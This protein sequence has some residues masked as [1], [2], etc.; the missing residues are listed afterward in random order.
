[1]R[2]WILPLLIGLLAT[3]A[4]AQADDPATTDEELMFLDGAPEA[5]PHTV[6]VHVEMLN[7][8]LLRSDSD[9]D[10]SEPIY[11][12]GGQSVGLLG[13]FMKPDLTW[14][15]R[16][17]LRLYYEAEIGLNVWSQHNPDQQDATASDVF[18]LKHREVYAQ[19]ELLDGWL[20][21]KVGYQR[22]NDPTRLF[23]DHWIGAAQLSSDL[24]HFQ[25]SATVGQSADPTYEGFR[26][27]DNNFSHDTFVYGLTATRRFMDFV[28]LSL[29][30]WGLDDARVVG[31]T[32]R[33]FTPVLNLDADIEVLRLGLDGAMQFG[34]AEGAAVDG[35]DQSHM[36]WAVQLYG[37]AQ[38]ARLGLKLNLL[39]LS[40]DDADGA[41]GANGAFHYSAKSRS[42]TLLFT[43]SE[44]RDTFDNF[45]EKLGVSRGGFTLIRPGMLLADLMVS[46]DVWR[47]IRPTL[48]VGY[49]RALNPDN[50]LGQAELGWEFDAGVEIELD[51]ALLF[52]LYGS[53]LI[54]GEGLAAHVNTIDLQATEPLL[55]CMSALKVFY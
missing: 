49:A 43:E 39:A 37:V 22:V 12:P 30:L 29:G 41:N 19:G 52:Q 51:D 26:V 48:I 50:A 10:L 46:Y 47:G 11:S 45:D 32:N 25:L 55:S 33:V 8:F 23:V 24:R 36:A 13:T 5:E 14:H 54:P 6:D 3:P 40:A 28:S 38:L 35:G 17:N 16:K 27:E 42:S 2:H 21:F 1:M 34:S 4:F 53:V 7:L 15:V 31:R 9:F 44:L 20:G 18:L